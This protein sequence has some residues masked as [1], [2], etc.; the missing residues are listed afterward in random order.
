MS[1]LISASKLLEEWNRLSIRGRTE[2]DQVIM[3]QPTVEPVR[4]EWIRQDD[5]FTKYMCSNCG[6]KNYQGY[7]NFCPNCGADMRGKKNE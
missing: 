6:S 7:E 1:D 3:T 4:G 2:F 5:T